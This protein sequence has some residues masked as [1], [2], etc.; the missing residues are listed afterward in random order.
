MK[1][2]LLQL[3][4]ITLPI[5]KTVSAEIK[6]IGIINKYINIS[7]LIIFFSL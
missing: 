2:K 7:W 4:C 6:E 3:L 1:K 5:F